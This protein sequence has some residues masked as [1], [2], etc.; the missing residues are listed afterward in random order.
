MSHRPPAPTTAWTSSETSYLRQLCRPLSPRHLIHRRIWEAI[1]RD[2]A[3]EQSR[4]LPGGP[5]HD[6]EPWPARACH[7]NACRVAH[8]RDIREEEAAQ[9]LVELARGEDEAAREAR[10]EVEVEA[11][12]TL[13]DLARADRRR[14]W[15]A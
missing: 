5:H 4:H 3:R 13:L 10:R 9:A 14:G 11:A 12:L 15:V 2:F 8:I 6:I 7:W 1:A